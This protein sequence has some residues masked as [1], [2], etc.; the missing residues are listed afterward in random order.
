VLLA[1]QLYKKKRWHYLQN[2]FGQASF[3]AQLLQILGVR[4]VVDGEVGLHGAQLVMLEAGAHALRA[5]GGADAPR[6]TEP[7]LHV[8]RV[9]IWEK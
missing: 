4:V 3:L 2:P 9:Q 5:G 8:F 7:H 1:V 6:T